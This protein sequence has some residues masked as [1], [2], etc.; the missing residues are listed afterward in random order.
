M[1]VSQVS[2]KSPRVY[3][4][5]A[6]GRKNI[7]DKRLDKTVILPYHQEAPR[8]MLRM[9]ETDNWADMRSDAL[10]S[11]VGYFGSMNGGSVGWCLSTGY[12]PRKHGGGGLHT[13]TI[14]EPSLDW[15]PWINQGG[16]GYEC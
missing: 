3:P 5:S 14:M 4:H 15:I 12:H 7:K 2:G 8:R 10:N 9:W 6:T 1:I 13:C 16:V 11:I